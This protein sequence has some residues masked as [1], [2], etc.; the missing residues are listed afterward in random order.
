MAESGPRMMI[1]HVKD[2]VAK[3][4]ALRSKLT[5]GVL[6]LE[7]MSSPKVRHLLNNLCN[8]EGCNYLEIGS[9]KGSTV[10]SAGFRNNGQFTAIESFRKRYGQ[11]TSP[12]GALLA[13][14]ERFS[15]SAPFVFYEADSWEFDVSLISPRV[16]VYFYD[17][18][19]TPEGT[20]KAF[21]HFNAALADTFVLVMDDWN[22]GRI[23]DATSR[24]IRR[25]YRILYA[26]ELFTPGRK[27]EPN[28]TPSSWWNGLY[29]AVLQKNRCRLPGDR[30][31]QS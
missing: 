17:G 4:C 11:E 28:D 25:S 22:R 2:A 23:R 8:F 7:G 9:W 24:A 27:H 18:D 15:R 6:A 30:R 5:D 13:N 19:H 20:G 29:V 14:K 31:V 3:A 1:K 10:I 12:K 16:N 21:T 26:R